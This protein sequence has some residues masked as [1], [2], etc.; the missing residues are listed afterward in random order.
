MPASMLD[1]AVATG[2]EIE[3]GKGAGIALGQVAPIGS[4]PTRNF[5]GSLDF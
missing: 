3:L 4:Q 1:T 5:T 2:S